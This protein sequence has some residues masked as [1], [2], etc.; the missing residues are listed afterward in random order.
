MADR[1]APS[2]RPLI[3]NVAPTHGP[4]D[5]DTDVPVPRIIAADARVVARQ[6][7]RSFTCMRASR[8]NLRPIARRSTR[9]SFAR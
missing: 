8:T 6:E 3:I 1:L 2:G 9:R 5:V 4:D 7:D